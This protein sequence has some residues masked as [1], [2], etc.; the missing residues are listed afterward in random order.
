MEIYLEAAATW[1]SKVP[2][3]NNK[4]MLFFFQSW[5]A[6]RG[7]VLLVLILNIGFAILFTNLFLQME[8]EED[9]WEGW[10]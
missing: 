8:E 2:I 7:L 4:L 3:D 9:T 10:P 1:H 6:S 5:S